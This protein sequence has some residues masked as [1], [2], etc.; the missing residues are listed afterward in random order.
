MTAYRKESFV[1][2]SFEYQIADLIRAK[3]HHEKKS[4]GRVPGLV[5][6]TMGAVGAMLAFSVPSHALLPSLGAMAA[7]TALLVWAYGRGQD[8]EKWFRTTFAKRGL[9][10]LELTEERFVMRDDIGRSSLAWEVVVHW[11]ETDEDFYVYR[12][13]TS[14]HVLPKRAFSGSE[15]ATLV[16][17]LLTDRVPEGG[18][19]RIA[20][21]TAGSW[22]PA[23]AYLLVFALVFASC[24]EA[25]AR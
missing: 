15:S 6:G 24:I 18:E 25:F 14:Y 13:A 12:D 10:T 8:V 11:V 7:V 22:I 21:A 5:I 4:R 3:A 16:R 17:Q 20:A 1:R 23:F 9:Q 2:A 19:A